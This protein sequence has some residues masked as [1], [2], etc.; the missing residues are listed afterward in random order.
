[1]E[2]VEKKAALLNSKAEAQISAFCNKQGQFSTKA[3]IE[4]W[5]V[6]ST[7]LERILCRAVVPVPTEGP[8]GGGGAMEDRGDWK[9]NSGLKSSNRPTIKPAHLKNRSDKL[10]V[11]NNCE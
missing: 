9:Q 5:K 3:V 8:R 2:N 6:V 10:S 4:K 11:K 7:E 1:M